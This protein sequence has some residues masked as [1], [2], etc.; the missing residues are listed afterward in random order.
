MLR[1]R[2]EETHEVR[3]ARRGNTRGESGRKVYRIQHFFVRARALGGHLAEG[4]V[5]G[6]EI[7]PRRRDSLRDRRRGRSRGGGAPE[8]RRGLQHS[9]P[10]VS[11]PAPLPPLPPLPPPPLPP[12]PPPPLPPLP[13]SRPRFPRSLRRRIPTAPPRPRFCAGFSP[14]GTSPLPPRWL[15]VPSRLC[16][17]AAAP[18]PTPPPRLDTP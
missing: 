3:V 13:R 12:L 4:T 15:R 2:D 5:R 8:R 18:R 16:P 10:L 7:T 14:R 17:S 6:E 1:W 9:R 11:A